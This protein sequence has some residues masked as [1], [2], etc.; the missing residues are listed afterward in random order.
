MKTAT[1]LIGALLV[2]APFHAQA[3]NRPTDAQILKMRATCKGVQCDFIPLTTIEL[4]N[5]KNQ[6]SIAT[7]TKSSV[8]EKTEIL[9]LSKSAEK[10]IKKLDK[11]IQ[12]LKK[13]IR[14]LQKQLSL[15]LGE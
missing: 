12:E 6:E 3:G 13:Q 4:A 2:M 5:P 14:E 9:K 1:I 8:S 15:L 10:K 11:E 7:P